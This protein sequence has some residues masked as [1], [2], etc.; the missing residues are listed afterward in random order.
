M[1]RPCAT[2]SNAIWPKGSKD[3]KIDRCL[4]HRPRSRRSIK[5]SCSQQSVG[6]LAA[7]SNRTRCGPMPRLA[8]YLAEQTGIRVSV[9]TVRQVLKAAEIVMSRPQ[10]KISSPDPEYL[11]KK[12]RLKRQETT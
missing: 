5:S 2:G 1:I 8:D 11:L 6:D 4:E 7:W 3:S 12:R 9:E 10:H